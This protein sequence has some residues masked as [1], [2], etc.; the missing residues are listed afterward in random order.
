MR[1]SIPIRLV[2]AGALAAFALPSDSAALVVSARGTPI[3]DGM[4]LPGE[5]DAAAVTPFMVALPDVGFEP[6]TLRVLNDDQNLYVAV[7]AQIVVNPPIGPVTAA[8][9]EVGFDVD[10]DF[11]VTSPGDDAVGLDSGG[12]TRDLFRDSMMIPTL[13]TSDGGTT[14]VTGFFLQGTLAVFELSHPLD[15]ADL[16]PHDIQ[17]DPG[18]TLDFRLLIRLSGVTTTADTYYPGPTQSPTDSLQLAVPEPDARLQ[19]GAT[20]LALALVRWRSRAA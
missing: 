13:D 16:P 9:L 18:T 11:T 4:L 19:G 15:S 20:L 10:H 1:A 8:D 7:T 17:V 14:D 2:T 12:A 6:A 5:W 3:L